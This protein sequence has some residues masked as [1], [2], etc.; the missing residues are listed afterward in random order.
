MASRFKQCVRVQGVVLDF[1]ELRNVH[2]NNWARLTNRKSKNKY[3]RNY[4][5]TMFSMPFQ[6]YSIPLISQAFSFGRETGNSDLVLRKMRSLP[7]NIPF[8]TFEEIYANMNLLE[9]D[10]F[11]NFMLQTKKL[12]IN[13]R[14]L[15][16]RYNRSP[17]FL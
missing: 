11:A 17:F 8:E 4:L 1:S 3:L 13:A 16:E 2:I 14:E 6:Y 5:K 15:H 7:V 10:S 12:T 9:Q